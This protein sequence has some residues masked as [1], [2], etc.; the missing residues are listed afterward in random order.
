M[1]RPTRWSM[2]AAVPVAACMALAA[3]DH[4]SAQVVQLPTFSSFSV[5]TTVSVP[6]RGSAYLGGVSRSA[7]GRSTF[8]VPGLPMRPFR[9]SAIGS[10]RS[11][12]HASVNVWIHDFEAMDRYLLGQ[13]SSG[14]DGVAVSGDRAGFRSTMPATRPEVER[15]Q[16]ASR[17]ALPAESPAAESPIGS[18]A[19][20]RR[21]RA[22]QQSARAAEALRFFERGEAAE[23][24]GKAAVAKIY[25]QMAARRAD[26]ELRERLAARI[27]AITAR[28]RGEG[29]AASP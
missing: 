8:G 22:A 15:R 21:R 6:D 20:E 11:A 13:P 26:G 18:V 29:L 19:E 23:S 9:N 1:I 10:T 5:G 2:R 3:T 16:W 12:S 14:G 27:E 25:Y 28:E 24:D 7:D 4:C 17:P